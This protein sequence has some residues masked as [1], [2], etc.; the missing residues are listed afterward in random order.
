MNRI[1]HISDKYFLIVVSLF[2]IF[3]VYTHGIE[4]LFYRKMHVL[5]LDNLAMT[6]S[7]RKKYLF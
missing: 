4:K 1:S 2:F 3:R 5:A 7:E 6:E